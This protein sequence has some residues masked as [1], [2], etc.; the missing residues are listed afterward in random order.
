MMYLES[1]ASRLS[2]PNGYGYGTDCG[3]NDGNFIAVQERAHRNTRKCRKE[4]RSGNMP[5]K[6]L[7]TVSPVGIP[8]GEFL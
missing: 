2:G 8:V 7:A 3:G 1:A 4:E 5:L 6:S